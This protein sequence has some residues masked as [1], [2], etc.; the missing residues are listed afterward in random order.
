MNS[1]I[2]LLIISC[3]VGFSAFAQSGNPQN[4]I[5]VID[6]LGIIKKRKQQI[7][8]SLKKEKQA[9]SILLR[10]KNISTGNSKENYLYEFN[11]QTG[12]GEWYKYFDTITNRYKMNNQRFR[13]NRT[14][15]FHIININAARFYL[16]IENKPNYYQFNAIDETDVFTKLPESVT[17]NNEKEEQNNAIEKKLQKA[18]SIIN[19]FKN[20]VVEIKGKL[21]EIPNIKLRNTSSDSTK[22]KSNIDTSKMLLEQEEKHLAELLK[23]LKDKDP[24]PQYDAAKTCVLEKYNSIYS[25]MESILNA[26]WLGYDDAGKPNIPFESMFR[27]L[28]VLLPLERHFYNQE[29]GSVTD[30]SEKKYRFNLN[31]NLDCSCSAQQVSII[32]SYKEREWRY[33][34]SSAHEIKQLMIQD[35]YKCSKD[36][37]DTISCC[38]LLDMINEDSEFSSINNVA[39]KIADLWT[40]YYKYGSEIWSDPF[41][42]TDADEV[43]Q[44]V[45]IKEVKTQKIFSTITTPRY[46]VKCAVK[47]NFSAGV[48]FNGLVE[49]IYSTQVSDSVFN[50]DST[51]KLPRKKVF[52]D[53]TNLFE[54]GITTLLHAYVTTGI[55]FNVGI[56][57]GLSISNELNSDILFG[58]SFMFGRNER[59]VLSTGLVLGKRQ[60][61]N[62]DIESGKDYDPLR[63][64]DRDITSNVWRTSWFASFTYNILG[65]GNVFGEKKSSKKN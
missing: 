18:N 34:L 9:I 41:T 40:T 50:Q 11:F 21:S 20:K 14:I 12:E 32:P 43:F 60:R 63:Y 54:Y 64:S 35:M 29:T 57:A 59:F 48:G 38:T 7:E 10:N 46:W 45:N 30:T 31:D 25:T 49:H 26:K 1:S 51:S 23:L 27:R 3:C 24:N 15:R 47:F 5:N 33:R 17:G 58:G 6:E 4:K 36:L 2:Y 42:V 56:A 55:P 13:Y 19:D 8:D 39:Q 53:D 62:K 61:L 28:R 52:R 37:C 44:N 16:D 65:K 22:I